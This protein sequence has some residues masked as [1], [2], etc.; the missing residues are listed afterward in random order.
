MPY[1]VEE[2][3][4]IIAE[5]GLNPD[6]YDLG[7]DERSFVPKFAPIQQNPPT[8]DITSTDLPKPT[9]APG[10]LESAGR[11]AAESFL[12]SA[13]GLATTAGALAL[14]PEPTLLT[15]VG[16]LGLG[17][18]S[19]VLASKAQRA[20]VPESIQKS[21]FTRPEDYEVNPKSTIMGGFVPSALTLRPT[22]QD[23]PEL[24][25][26]VK[27]LPRALQ[28]GRSALTSPQIEALLNA[29]MSVGP[30]G[31]MYAADVASG[32][33]DFNLG[34]AALE[35]LP[36]ILM[37]KPTAVGRKLGFASPSEMRAGFELAE[38][39]RV[40]ESARPTEVT[41]PFVPNQPGV[42]QFGIVPK[43]EEVV[44]PGKKPKTGTQKPFKSAQESASVFEQ[45]GYDTAPL[46]AAEAEAQH[47]TKLREA[48]F[49]KAEAEAQIAHEQATAA[50]IEASRLKAE[51]ERRKIDLAI[52]GKKGFGEEAP[53]AERLEAKVTGKQLTEPEVRPVIEETA[54]E[55]F[56]IQEPEPP[57]TEAERIQD[58]YDR[59]IRKSEVSDL[60]L[61]KPIET[62]PKELKETIKRDINRIAL[63]RRQKVE[64]VPSLRN[65]AGKEIL[66]QYD[67]ATKTIKLN[68]KLYAGDTGPHEISHGR[69][70]DLL[71]SADKRDRNLVLKGL[72]FS[73]PQNR[74]FKTV[75]DFRKLSPEEQVAIEERFTK[76]VGPE[77][78]RQQLTELF[79]NKKERF[80]EWLGQV[81]THFKMKTGLADSDELFKHFSARQR[82]DAP[83]YLRTEMSG[84]AAKVEGARES[85][86]E[87]KQAPVI[88]KGYQE[89]IG[90]MKG[91]HLYNLTEDI[92]GTSFVKGST[93]TEKSLREAGYEIPA[94][95][96][97]KEKG[98]RNSEESDLSIKNKVDHVT[99]IKDYVTLTPVLRRLSDDKLFPGST[100]AG[101]LNTIKDRNISG[102]FE[103]GFISDKG[104]YG[105][106]YWDSYNNVSNAT[107]Y[108]PENLK[109][110]LEFDKELVSE[111]TSMERRFQIIDEIEKIDRTEE[112]NPEQRYSES[113]D[114]TPEFEQHT[115]SFLDKLFPSTTQKVRNLG[116]NT[117]KHVGDKADLYLS[118]KSL[119]EGKYRND[120]IAEI[121]SYDKDVRDTV[122]RYGREMMLTG[123]SDISLL[124]E[125]Q[126]LYDS[127]RE[128]LKTVADENTKREISKNPNYWPQILDS[129]VANVWNKAPNSP[130][131][132]MYQ[133]EWMAHAKEQV[134]KGRAKYTPDELKNI[135]SDYMA[136]IGS[137]GKEATLGFG[138]LRKAAGLGLP[139]SMQ[140]NNLLSRFSRYG[141][142]V[143][144]DMASAEV[145]ESDPVMRYMFRLK[146]EKGQVLTEAPKLPSGEVADDAI[147]G[148]EALQNV[149]KALYNEY[150]NIQSPRLNAAQRVIS[151]ALLGTATGL[152]DVVTA[153]LNVS[154]VIG[155]RNSDALLKGLS[156][157]RES[158]KDSFSS[159]ARQMKMNELEFGS[160]AHPDTLTKWFSQ[161][162]DG[163]RKYSGRESL[164]QA[165]RIYTFSVGKLAALAEFGRNDAS[166][167]QWLKKF[168][169]TVDGGVEQ[170]FGKNGS[171][172]PAEVVNQIAKAIVDR[173]QGTYDAR[174]LPIFVMDGPLAPFFS[175]SRWSY[176]KAGVISQDILKPAAQGNF[177]PLLSYTLGSFLTGGAI[178]KLNELMSS[179]KRG[180]EPTLDEAQA[181]D[182]QQVRA[183]VNLLQ[184]GS[185]GGMI[186]D[187][188]KMSTEGLSGH[189]MSGGLSFPLGDFVSE[190]LGKNLSD[191]SAAIQS[192]EEPVEAGLGLIERILVDSVQTARLASYATWRKDEIERKNSYRD[193]RLWQ[194]LS[195]RRTPESDITRPN[196][197]VGK[198]SKD[199]KRAKTI[200][201]GV[202]LLPAALEKVI[203][204]SG[205]DVS[206]MLRGFK[207]LKA[208]NYQTFPSDPL[209]MVAYYE[210][211]KKTQ[212]DEEAANRLGD[213]FQQKMVNKAKASLVP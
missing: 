136:A 142:R 13:A 150:T 105:S 40:A 68:S 183:V 137:G 147:R 106:K 31:A 203:E 113:S 95:E 19:S 135:L 54:A 112:R 41:E 153:P 202:E 22:L 131:G 21:I 124:P 169:T 97:S 177:I 28:V 27:A 184:L 9:S 164:E 61:T 3:K 69:I 200:E 132:K 166:A 20:V 8:T 157:F 187:L 77:G 4:A 143:A 12:P 2:K 130:E 70:L 92:P 35:T 185:F 129:R 144:K 192:G 212:G 56:P 151:S 168:G 128:Y 99:K 181:A 10:M 57:M 114:L 134:A 159:N 125:E 66:G 48:A 11:G 208:N 1:T 6:E 30:S 79:G 73:D 103:P 139:E 26:G 60:D 141:T 165:S 173:A 149:E 100:H 91:F 75:E 180:N 76:S 163:L 182:S 167:H 207:S 43:A 81:G 38:R 110:V 140:D 102:T 53:A 83:D 193:I 121:T 94:A 172:I 175:L 210:Y 107:E 39:T 29:G 85:E 116:G 119:L 5:H 82:L 49:R 96:K 74:K 7:P 72:E 108:S 88:Y 126:S 65:K 71:D 195:G 42:K 51:N 122:D 36:G 55:K 209:E 145:L 198:T 191:Y 34:E 63:S 50:E 170:Y 171:E 206:K 67:P 47:A 160:A 25:G 16:A 32:N 155:P 59:G 44:L 194:E 46:S 196:E 152:R 89:G 138:A 146:D 162:A 176:E 14:I 87:K 205:G 211:L 178:Q 84:G 23:I 80:K 156:T 118:K 90:K 190:T 78:Y 161:L 93:V 111:K 98:K 154:A 101:A 58:E 148:K 179:G 197:L 174:G 104:T 201:E 186:G 109:K 133:K 64:Y 189:R 86:G 213:F 117:A 37:T 15:K 199:F 115:P 33:R 123:K 158:I 45:K 188:M 204:S 127:M 52:G 17:V 24:I 18:L 120:V 62:L